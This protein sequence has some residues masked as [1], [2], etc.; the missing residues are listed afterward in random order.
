VC[1]NEGHRQDSST[2][3][4]KSETKIEREGV[5]SLLDTDRTIPIV[6][7]IGRSNSGKTTFIEKLIA[8]LESKGIRVAIAKQH[9]HDVDVDVVGKDSWR[10]AQA[11][12]SCSI[13]ST[14]A[15]L[16]VVHKMKEQANLLELA[17]VA[18]DAGCD[19][20]I[21]E[22]FG[23]SDEIAHYVV[24]RTDRAEEPL[25]LPSQ[26]VGIITD[27]DGLAENWKTAEK[28]IFDINN[29]PDFVDYLLATF[30]LR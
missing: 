9:H 13:F 1:H 14:P 8:L 4:A 15:Q 18:E 17:K 26:S 19:I 7:L 12:A 22:S 23:S 2:E 27:D 28:P 25:L 16:S 24:A 5:D 20:L 3:T 29:V 11:G 10:Y 21:A 30:P 6:S